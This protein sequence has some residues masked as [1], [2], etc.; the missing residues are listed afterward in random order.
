MISL[1]VNNQSVNLTESAKISI[2]KNSPVLNDQV[3]AFSY[4]FAV[5]TAKNQKL[6][7]YPGRLERAIDIPTQNFILDEDGVQ[8]LRGQIDYDEITADETGLVLQS[9]NTEF[10]KLMDGKNLSD[11]DFGSEPWFTEFTV[12]NIQ[13]KLNEW[14]IKNAAEINDYVCCPFAVKDSDG[15]QIVVNNLDTSVSPAYLRIDVDSTTLFEKYYCLQFSVSWLLSKIYEYAGFIVSANEIL[16]SEF[17]NV[18]IFGN[19]LRIYRSNMV[20]QEIQT[21]QDPPQVVVSYEEGYTAEFIYYKDLMPEIDVLEFIKVAKSLL[22]ITIDIDEK[23]KKVSFLYNKGIL[24]T[25]IDNSYNNSELKGY[26]HKEISKSKGFKLFFSGQDDNMATDYD[27][28]HVSSQVNFEFD[29]PTPNAGWLNSIIE[30]RH[31]SRFYKCEKNSSDQYNWNEI[32]RLKMVT[33]GT[34]ETK[35]EIY[36]K[37]PCQVVVNNIDM[38]SLNITIDTL[39]NYLNIKQMYFSLFQGNYPFMGSICPVLSFDRYSTGNGTWDYGKSLKPAYLYETV[40]KE[41]INLKTYRARECTKYLQ[42]SLAEV[43]ALQFRKRYL[44]SGVSI[45]LNKVNFDLPYRGIVKINGFT[46]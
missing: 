30:V 23:L 19:I 18:V 17:K 8:I 16:E 42:L 5:P 40:Y 22:C 12:S 46:T 43:V 34:E 33:S 26:I 2:E 36:A 6:L 9:G 13:D 20:E 29:L 28:S 37:V 11:L 32:A 25:P 35:F 14:N 41:F 3:G 1:K 44:I 21:G 24:T 45:L 10:S 27:L 15:N 38:P 39:V 31:S 7:G 4:P